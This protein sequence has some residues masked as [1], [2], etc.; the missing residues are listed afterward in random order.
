MQVIASKGSVNNDKKRKPTSI[1][2][3]V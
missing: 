3:K 1:S 2:T